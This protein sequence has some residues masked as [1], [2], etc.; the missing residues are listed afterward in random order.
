MLFKHFHGLNALVFCFLDESFVRPSGTQKKN[1]KKDGHCNEKHEQRISKRI[2]V[3]VR[4]SFLL[5]RGGCFHGLHQAVPFDLWLPYHVATG[6]VIGN[7]GVILAIFLDD[8]ANHA[9]HGNADCSLG[10]RSEIHL[11]DEFVINHRRAIEEARNANNLSTIRP[12]KLHQFSGSGKIIAHVFNNNTP[13]TLFDLVTAK[14]KLRFFA[15]KFGFQGND[16][17]FR[18]D[19]PNSGCRHPKGVGKGIAADWRANKSIHLAQINHRIDAPNKNTCEKFEHVVVRLGLGKVGINIA[20]KLQVL[21][22][23]TFIGA[24]VADKR[25]KPLLFRILGTLIEPSASAKSFKVIVAGNLNCR[26][27][28]Y[29]SSPVT[30]AI[31]WAMS[32]AA[33]TDPPISGGGL[34]MGRPITCRSI[35]DLAASSGVS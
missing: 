30:L 35:P 24:G 8:F 3:K 11:T 31:S 15:R 29:T 10:S 23:W 25:T 14:N 16:L 12:D 34:R 21:A 28:D 26:E 2:V 17:F 19:H 7:L 5:L 13:P 33:F 18:L 27:Q 20:N 32:W 9:C 4:H 22:A 1:T 6:N